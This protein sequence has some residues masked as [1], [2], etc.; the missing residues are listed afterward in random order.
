MS[1]HRLSMS[2]PSIS[3]IITVKG[4]C[5]FNASQKNCIIVA[6]LASGATAFNLCLLRSSASSIG[7]YFK[8]WFGRQH[9]PS[10]LISAKLCPT[11]LYLCTESNFFFSSNNRFHVI[12]SAQGPTDVN[13]SDHDLFVEGVELAQFW[14]F[15]RRLQHLHVVRCLL[16]WF[17]LGGQQRLAVTVQLWRIWTGHWKHH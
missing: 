10:D 8:H 1:K 7:D 11:L 16:E 13:V 2:G 4:F 17:L 14:L 6:S 9:D 12:Y 5:C 3:P 15:G